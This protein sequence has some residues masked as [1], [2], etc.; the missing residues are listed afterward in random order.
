MNKD[1]NITQRHSMSI[2]LYIFM[3]D[4]FLDMFDEGCFTFIVKY[5]LRVI[6]KRNPHLK[7]R[8]QKKAVMYVGTP[9]N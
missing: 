4:I 6:S 1:D 7:N 8:M 9:V 2:I 5:F 3:S